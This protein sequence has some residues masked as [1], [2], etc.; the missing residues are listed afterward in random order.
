MVAWSLQIFSSTV[1]LYCTFFQ[2]DE[3]STNKRFHAK[4]AKKLGRSQTKSPQPAE[5]T[6]SEAVG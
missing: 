4:K 3:L 1:V 5:G 6:N 2:M